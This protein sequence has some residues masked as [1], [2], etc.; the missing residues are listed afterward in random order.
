MSPTWTLRR[1]PKTGPVGFFLRGL[2][3]CYATKR[4]GSSYKQLYLK[5]LCIYVSK[6]L[7]R[8]TYIFA[9]IVYIH[10]ICMYMPTYLYLHLHL[11]LYQYYFRKQV[12]ATTPGQASSP[13]RPC[14]R[15]TPARRTSRC[16]RRAGLRTTASITRVLQLRK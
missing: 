4:L 15:G 2:L 7:Y 14:R 8:Y 1:M 12:W 5:V 13:P 9:K 6:Y 10:N 16:R 11:Y 3:G